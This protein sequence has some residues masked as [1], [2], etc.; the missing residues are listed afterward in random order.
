VT[1]PAEIAPAQEQP[2][3]SPLAQPAGAGGAKKRRA[4]L[5]AGAGV[6][7]AARQQVGNATSGAFNSTLGRVGAALPG[8]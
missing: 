8:R 3:A 6:A 1:A 2:A 7:D 4:L 5:Q